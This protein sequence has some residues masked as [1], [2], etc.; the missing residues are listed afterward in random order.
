MFFMFIYIHIVVKNL[1]VAWYRTSLRHHLVHQPSP[2]CLVTIPVRYQSTGP[3]DTHLY[4]VRGEAVGDV[5]LTARAGAT[6]AADRRVEVFPPLRLSPRN[7][8]VAV[9]SQYQLSA[10]GGP[11]ADTDVRFSSS[12]P[13]A[14]EVGAAGLVTARRP[15]SVRLT[16]RVADGEPATGDHTVYSEVRH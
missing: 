14:A 4:E 2:G 13:A 5:T 6:A 10:S 9:G 8:T 11:R 7:R 12:A 16:G 3:D 15:G 1:L